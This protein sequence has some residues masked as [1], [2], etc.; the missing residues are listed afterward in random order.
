MTQ[1]TFDNERR[2]KA[3]NIVLMFMH[4]NVYIAIF[5]KSLML[6]DDY[7]NYSRFVDITNQC[8]ETKNH[9]TWEILYHVIPQ[10][11]RKLFQLGLAKMC[12]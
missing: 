10:G 6:S 9:M 12:K 2:I 8:C 3:K 5:T 11:R 4:A 1:K 7:A